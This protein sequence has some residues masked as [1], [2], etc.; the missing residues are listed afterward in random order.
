MINEGTGDREQPGTAGTEGG[1][2]PT[3]VPAAPELRISPDGAPNGEVVHSDPQVLERPAQ[4]RFT[5]EYKRGILRQIANCTKD[6]EIGAL[7]RREGLYTSL[8]S[9]WRRQEEQGRLDASTT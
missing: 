7:L 5:K 4:R 9:N 8:V 3:G 1:R 6:G 2:R